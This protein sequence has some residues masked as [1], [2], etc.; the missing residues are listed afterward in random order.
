MVVTDF[1]P[2][3][4]RIEKLFLN[5]LNAGVKEGAGA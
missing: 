1:R 2:K 4:N 5:I 3:G